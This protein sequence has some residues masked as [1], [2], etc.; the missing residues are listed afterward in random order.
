MTEST[1]ISALKSGDQAAYRKL[2]ENYQVP[3]LKVC[4]GFLHDDGDAADIVQDT[5]IEVFLS[6]SNFRGEAKLST[7]LYRIAVNKCLNLLRKRRLHSLVRFEMLPA[8]KNNPHPEIIDEAPLPGNALENRERTSLVKKTIDLLPPNQRIAF[9]LHKY[10]DL[11]YKEIAEVMGIS[12]ASVESLLHRAR[13][14]L[15]KKLYTAYKK[16]LL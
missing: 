7:W 13:V 11:A 10:Q 8:R 9:V 6:V 4:R 3:L 5:F 12:V 14:N 2:I 15:H 1:I 16:N